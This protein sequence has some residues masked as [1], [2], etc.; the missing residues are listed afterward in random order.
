MFVMALLPTVN[1]CA[2]SK[3]SLLVPDHSH[4][5]YS[6]TGTQKVTKVLNVYVSP[7]VIVNDSISIYKGKI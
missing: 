3:M 2:G 5:T 7:G 4:Q 1:A 6:S